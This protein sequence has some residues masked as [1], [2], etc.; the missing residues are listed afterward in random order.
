[1][2]RLN[3]QA[4]IQYWPISKIK[5]YKKNHKKH[6]DE[7]IQKLVKSI[8]TFGFTQPLVVN[9]EGVL[10][11]GEGRYLAS[12][13]LGLDAVP[14]LVKSYSEDEEKILRI[15]DNEL[16]IF[17]VVSDFQIKVEELKGLNIDTDMLSLTNMNPSDFDYAIKSPTTKELLAHSESL[18][19]Q[20]FEE[21]EKELAN[22]EESDEEYLKNF[23]HNEESSDKENISLLNPPSEK[24]FHFYVEL[25]TKESK[26]NIK[27]RV[28][29]L[30]QEVNAIVR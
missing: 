22:D 27:R 18:S 11:I 16:N 30:L 10:I 23:E 13:K 8:S 21:A 14:V 5:K 1:M 6:S 25:K 19:S 29:D 28:S 7:Q 4:E 20:M 17:G 26:E 9:T 12:K 24:T 15:A 2:E 3:D